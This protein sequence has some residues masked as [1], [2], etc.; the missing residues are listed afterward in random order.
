MNKIYK[1]LKTIKDECEAKNCSECSFCSFIR[2]SYEVAPK[3]WD[4]TKLFKDKGET[5]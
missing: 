1:A 5:L 4:L 3:D 2:D